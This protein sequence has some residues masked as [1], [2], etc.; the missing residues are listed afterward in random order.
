MEASERVIHLLEE[1]R[2]I[3]KT[4]VEESRRK[5]DRSLQT[6]D[7][8]LR[9]QAEFQSLYK[10]VLVVGAVVVLL[11]IAGFFYIWMK[12]PRT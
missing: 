4:W 1:I 9:R 11:G 6:Q 12:A 8:A 2:D 7:E 3:Q 10:R 5:V